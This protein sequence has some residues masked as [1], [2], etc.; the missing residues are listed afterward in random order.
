MAD[1]GGCA[2]SQT[3][4]IQVRAEDFVFEL[5]RPEEQNNVEQAQSQNSCVRLLT[6]CVRVDLSGHTLVTAE[7]ERKKENKANQTGLDIFSSLILT[8]N[9]SSRQQL[10]SDK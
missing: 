9:S 1:G 2:P 4:W 10:S 6:K 5:K 7:P 3:W 8:S